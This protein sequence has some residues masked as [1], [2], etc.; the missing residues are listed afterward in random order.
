VRIRWFV[1][2][3]V[4]ALVVV[5]ASPIAAGAKSVGL[6][7]HGAITFVDESGSPVLFP[8][9]TCASVADDYVAKVRVG[10]SKA[11]VVTAE[12]ERSVSPLSFDQDLCRLSFS[13]R[14]P[15]GEHLHPVGGWSSVRTLDG[16]RTRGA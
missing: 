16:D 9:S 1:V 13:T 5:F 4:T 10:G 6:S 3:L 8:S 14:L 15:R 2:V 7:L 12:L 11:S